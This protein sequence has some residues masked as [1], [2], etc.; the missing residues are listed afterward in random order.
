MSR[1]SF[2]A[3]QALRAMNWSALKDIATSPHLFRRRRDHPRPDTDALFF[4]RAFHAALLEPAVFADAYVVEPDFGDCRKKE[5]KATRDAWRAENATK[6]PLSNGDADR[7]AH[8]VNAIHGHRQ[9]HAALVG[10]NE[11]TITWQDPVTGLSCKGRLDTLGRGVVDIKTARDPSPGAF[12]RA[13]AGYLYH[14]QAAWYHDGLIASGR[15][16][17]PEL[18]IILAIQNVEP[19]DVAVYRVDGQALESGRALYRRLLTTFMA[20]TA[21]NWWPGVAPEILSLPMPS[22]ASETEPEPS[23]DDGDF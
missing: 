5:N 17:H 7:I 3:Y 6:I 22:W 23:D 2:E 1:I 21:A 4:G 18:P 12:S 8:M 11:E 10:C 14:G 20:C 15:L 16:T 13:S 9:A 19:W